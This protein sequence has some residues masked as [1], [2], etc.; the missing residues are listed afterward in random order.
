MPDG[1]A[2]RALQSDSLVL[3]LLL[4]IEVQE[5]HSM[6]QQ[7]LADMLKEA[8]SRP[9]DLATGPMIRATLISMSQQDDT[10]MSEEH[11]LIISTHYSVADGWSMGVLFRDLSRAYNMLKLGQ[12]ASLFIAYVSQSI[13]RAGA[14][15]QPKTNK[16]C[17]LS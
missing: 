11:T 6:D 8:A 12:G 10:M 1:R 3:P 5:V 17:F 14:F 4:Q 16:V 2:L 9:F 7:H 15:H 13:T